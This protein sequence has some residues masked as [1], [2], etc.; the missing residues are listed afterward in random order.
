M[1][2]LL[3]WVVG[4]LMDEE[5]GWRVLRRIEEYRSKENGEMGYEELLKIM[6]VN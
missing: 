3:D 4:V 2:W 1:Y 5:R 6:K